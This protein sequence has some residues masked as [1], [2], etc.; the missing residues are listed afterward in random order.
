[1][2]NT[3][4]ETNDNNNKYA[5]SPMKFSSPHGNIGISFLAPLC[6]VVQLTQ[7]GFMHFMHYCYPLNITK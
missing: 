1:M 4:F 3:E 2:C 6:T 5:Y 7:L